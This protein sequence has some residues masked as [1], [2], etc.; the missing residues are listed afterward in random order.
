[1]SYNINITIDIPGKPK[2]K[3]RPRMVKGKIWTPSSPE[4]DAVAMMMLPHKGKFADKRNLSFCCWFYGSNP[5]SDADNM[6]KLYAD[7]AVKAGVIDDDRFIVHGFFEKRDVD[8]EGNPTPGEP[9]TRVR[10][11]QWIL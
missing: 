7:A 2:S 10:V 3:A 4:E 5:R 9:S 6:W 1:M 8:N 11:G